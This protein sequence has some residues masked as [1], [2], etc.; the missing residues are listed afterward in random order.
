M[1]FKLILELI[2]TVGFPITACL[3]LGIFIFKIYNKSEEREMALRNEISACQEINKEAIKTLT[4][5]AERLGVI[6]DDVKEIKED[7]IILTERT[8]N[9]N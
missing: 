1:D 3:A 5:Y 2:G 8:N 7:I 4:L 9:N 6:E